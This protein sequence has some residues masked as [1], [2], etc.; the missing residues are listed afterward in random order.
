[1]TIS[2]TPEKR[3]KRQAR[4][5][6]RSLVQEEEEDDDDE[7]TK[8]YKQRL[9][10]VS[11]AANAFAIVLFAFSNHGKS[12]TMTSRSSNKRSSYV[13]RKTTTRSLFSR[14]RT[15][16]KSVLSISGCRT[17]NARCSH[18]QTLRYGLLP[19]F[20]RRQSGTRQISQ[21]HH[22]SDTPESEFVSARLNFIDVDARLV[23]ESQVSTCATAISRWKHLHDRFHVAVR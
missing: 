20:G 8:I 11:R 14:T 15:S 9:R 2:L 19:A 1:M 3:K 21:L 12:T 16:L 13:R 6:N 4:K 10:N 7:E 17:E 22:F 23:E 18:V 5:T